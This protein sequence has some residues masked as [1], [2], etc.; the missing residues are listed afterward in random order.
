MLL[1]V[2]VVSRN[3][4]T[5]QILLFV[6]IMLSVYQVRQNNA[7]KKIKKN[8]KKIKQSAPSTLENDAREPHG[9]KKNER[10]TLNSVER[11]N[12]SQLLVNKKVSYQH[13]HQ[14]GLYYYAN[15]LLV[16]AG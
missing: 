14:D 3:N 4:N 12:D 11:E 16:L 8:L 13:Q 2:A 1:L 5:L 10:M 15:G 6:G 7:Q 9:T